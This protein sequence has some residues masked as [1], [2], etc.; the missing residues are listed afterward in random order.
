MHIDNLLRINDWKIKKFFILI[1][2]LQ[3]ATFGVI[4]AG[5]LGLHLPVLRPLVRFLYLL[6]VPGYLILRALKVHDL[7]S[8]DTVLYAIGA[9]LAALM[10]TG[11]LLN[12]F[13]PVFHVE[14]PLSVLPITLT[15][16]ALVLSLS[17]VCYLRDRNFTS[18]RRVEL[19]T[20]SLR[21]RCFWVQSWASWL[22]PRT[23]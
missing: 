10:M 12:V 14:K 18:H 11:V 2:A 19:A 17:V 16:S 9:S 4:G 13:G 21:R 15:I 23:Q 1:F 7:E 22:L 8:V 6:F 20:S 3:L 5:L